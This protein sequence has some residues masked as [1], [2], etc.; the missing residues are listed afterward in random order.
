MTM[1]IIPID[2]LSVEERE[3]ASGIIANQGKN[4]GRLRAGKPKIEYSIFEENGRKLRRPTDKTGKVAYL[5]RMVAFHVS[6][7]PQH[8]CLPVLAFVDLPGTYQDGQVLAKELD[9]IVN[10]IIDA[11]P[12]K[13]WQG[14]NRWAKALGY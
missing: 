11:M 9:L 5:W 4:K 3:I 8:Q 2:H 7:T 6:P 14:I 13:E 12:R 1:P 10:K